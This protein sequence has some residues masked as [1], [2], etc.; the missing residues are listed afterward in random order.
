MDEQKM[1]FPDLNISGEDAMKMVEM[2]TNDLEYS[3]KLS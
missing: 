2:T 3:K 1:W